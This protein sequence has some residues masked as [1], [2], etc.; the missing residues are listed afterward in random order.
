LIYLEKKLKI[1][2]LLPVLVPENSVG[3]STCTAE[4]CHS[5][6]RGILGAE[7]WRIWVAPQPPVETGIRG[8]VP[9]RLNQNQGGVT[10]EAGLPVVIESSLQNGTGDREYF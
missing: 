7:L 3:E 2:Q 9:V 8:A 5:V 4:C 1:K 6:W 10:M